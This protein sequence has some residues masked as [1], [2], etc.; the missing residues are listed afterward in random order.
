MKSAV[1]FLGGK[2]LIVDPLSV[3]PKHFSGFEMI[4]VQEDERYAANCLTVWQK[5]LMPAGFPRLAR[6][7]HNRGLQPV[8]LEMSEF[9][10]ADGGVT[11]L[12]LI[13]P[14]IPA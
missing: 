14:A 10:K 6:E 5:V 7:I 4:L 2:L 9:E 8:E 3:D 11:C 12:S 1:S 13:I